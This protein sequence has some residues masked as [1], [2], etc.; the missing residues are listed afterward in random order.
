ME[1]RS[2]QPYLCG[3][4][5]RGGESLMRQVGNLPHPLLSG[6]SSHA[7]HLWRSRHE[8]D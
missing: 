3:V 4:G 5:K 8:R 2:E 6:H 1:E 7:W